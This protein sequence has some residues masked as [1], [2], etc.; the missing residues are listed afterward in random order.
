MHKRQST[1]ISGHLVSKNDLTTLPGGPLIKAAA[2][3]GMFQNKN[4]QI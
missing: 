1:Q 2:E 3:A 4:Q